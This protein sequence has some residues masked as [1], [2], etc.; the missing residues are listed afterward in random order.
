MTLTNRDRQNPLIRR[1]RRHASLSTLFRTADMASVPVRPLAAAPILG[2]RIASVPTAATSDLNRTAIEDA[3]QRAMAFASSDPQDQTGADTIQS[4][5]RPIAPASGQLLAGQERV[6]SLSTVPPSTVTVAPPAMAQTSARQPVNAALTLGQ[7]LA[8]QRTTAAVPVDHPTMPVPAIPA[9]ARQ[10]SLPAV[11]SGRTVNPPPTPVTAPQTVA[12][13]VQRQAQ[14]AEQ[15]S[16]DGIDDATWSR[17]QT[18]YRKYKERDA[19]GGSAASATSVSPVQTQPQSV[20][21]SQATVPPLQRSATPSARPLR[22]SVISEER[23]TPA[24]APTVAPQPASPTP[25]EQ[26]ELRQSAAV[27]AGSPEEMHDESVQ[28]LGQPDDKST[29]IFSEPEPEPLFLASNDQAA[30]GNV[31]LPS[32]APAPINPVTTLVNRQPDSLPVQPEQPVAATP[33]HEGATD[34]GAT[35]EGATTESTSE[36]DI[37]KAQPVVQRATL[38]EPKPTIVQRAVVKDA[39]KDETTTAATNPVPTTIHGATESALREQPPHRAVRDPEPPLLS[40]ESDA[41]LDV[42]LSE[43]DAV[44]A[45][46]NTIGEVPSMVPV[47]P[48]GNTSEQVSVDGNVEI[49]SV[50]AQ[51]A[52]VGSTNSLVTP[53]YVEPATMVEVENAPIQNGSE[54]PAPGLP[55]QD[56]WPVQRVSPDDGRTIL[57][58]GSAPAVQRDRSEP[59][60]E[61]VSAPPRLDEAVWNQLEKRETARPTESSVHVIAPR[62]PRPRAKRVQSTATP[63]ANGEDAAPDRTTLQRR[64]LPP[65]EASSTQVADD[66]TAAENRT[67]HTALVQTDIGALPAD[68]WTM[69]GE[70]APLLPAQPVA[71]QRATLPATA[72]T[73]GFAFTGPINQQARDERPMTE[74]SLAEVPRT[75]DLYQEP[76]LERN[77]AAGSVTVPSR[78]SATVSTVAPLLTLTLA[79]ESDQQAAVIQRTA[80]P[81]SANTTGGENATATP[82]ST[83]AAID[84]DEL[85]RLVY[86]ELRRKLATERERL[87]PLRY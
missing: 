31:A 76:M 24:P 6:E 27:D 52:T 54:P 41:Q 37:R 16:A 59:S 8:I 80:V 48:A 53:D 87:R 56:A 45:I 12:E 28:P 11:P 26:P 7:T 40:A 17:L 32:P 79:D 77:S 67:A 23:M 33:T 10:P 29:T 35:D 19:P 1:V 57:H 64:P 61:V 25:E 34:E 21:A 49:A 43:A 18:A 63:A 81:Q 69:I 22:R 9:A 39:V 58:R 46:T 73:D 82:K 42:Q 47:I 5:G 38:A 65:Q 75:N 84:T 71:I 13:P 20:R 30:L 50:Q 2:Q 62:R 15:G 85:A 36:L 60:D 4:E 14:P 55:L 74:A 70:P 3:A 66:V 72:H 44:G 83:G 86:D 78:S 51:E 68:L